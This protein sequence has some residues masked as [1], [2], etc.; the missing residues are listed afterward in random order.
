MNVL[1][2]RACLHVF[3]RDLRPVDRCAVRILRRYRCIQRMLYPGA[4]DIVDHELVENTE[5]AVFHGQR[6]GHGLSF[7]IF[8]IAVDGIPE[9][10]LVFNEKATAPE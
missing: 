3:Q 10:S 1:G 7:V 6:I 5:K 4:A 9:Y 8:L 2:V